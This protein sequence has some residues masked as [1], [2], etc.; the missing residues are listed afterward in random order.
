M[1]SLKRIDGFKSFFFNSKI[2][3]GYDT[4]SMSSSVPCFYVC[5]AAMYFVIVEQNNCLQVSIFHEAY[6]KVFSPLFSAE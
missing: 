5:L 4:P 3:P 6:G 2:L 1:W